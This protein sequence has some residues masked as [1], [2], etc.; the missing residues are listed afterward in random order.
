MT[1]DPNPR[2]RILIGAAGTGTAFAACTAI[3]RYW[4]DSVE[5]SAMDTNP[6]YLVT[7]SLLADHYFQV[8]PFRS[9]EFVD[10]LLAILTDHAIDF[11][12]PLYPQEIKLAVELKHSRRLPTAT[13]L[14]GPG[15]EACNVASDK[16]FAAGWLSEHG[17]PSPKTCLGIPDFDATHYCIKPRMGTG[18]TGLRLLTKVELDAICQ[19][20][21][22]STDPSDGVI[23]QEQC[24]APELTV[25]V[26]IGQQNSQSRVLCRER[27]EI[28]SGVSTKVRITEDETITTLAIQLGTSLN[29]LG[30]F[31]FQVMRNEKG[32]CV[33]D[34]N[35]RPG[36]AS[37]TCSVTGNDFYGA[38]FA[39]AFGE[40]TEPFFQRLPRAVY[41]TRQY[42]DFLMIENDET[43]L[44]RL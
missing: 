41:V 9:P 21:P 26:F 27:L 43:P 25:D 29:Y 23:I 28:K 36:A 20:G 11:Y 33:I 4:G 22:L 5:L 32:W 31:C 35:P 2:K 17:L 15:P 44:L 6:H 1:S 24:F 12:L 18:S 39:L 19:T 42:S 30:A 37:A 16:Y 13:R 10:Q 14:I 34:V 40:N 8:K 7:S 38:M 3:R